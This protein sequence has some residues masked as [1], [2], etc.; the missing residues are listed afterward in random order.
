MAMVKEKYSQV[1]PKRA[2]RR[3]ANPSLRG[4]LIDQVTA[5]L[6]PKVATAMTQCKRAPIAIWGHLTQ[7]VQFV[8]QTQ[9][10]L[11]KAEHAAGRGAGGKED[12]AAS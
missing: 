6:T 7:L 5:R 1:T 8:G 12:G 3:G 11:F 4:L 2:I 9:G 10:Q